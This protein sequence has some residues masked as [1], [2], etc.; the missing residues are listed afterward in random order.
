VAVVACALFIVDRA[1]PR[2]VAT[3]TRFRG[4]PKVRSYRLAPAGGK[5]RAMV[6]I[7]V[8][9]ILLGSAL[10]MLGIAWL[11]QLRRIAELE[12]QV[13]ELDRTVNLL[14]FTIQQKLDV[15]IDDDTRRSGE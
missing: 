4:R 3:R 7:F 14:W 15:D 13:L 9:N 5:R 12:A 8:L 2:L 6:G 1:R 11:R 10:I